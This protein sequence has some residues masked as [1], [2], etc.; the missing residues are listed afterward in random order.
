MAVAVLLTS[1]DSASADGSQTGLLMG[2]VVDGAGLPLPQVE[3][4]VDG[5]Q[6]DRSAITDIEGYFRFPSLEIGNYEVEAELLGLRTTNPVRVYLDTTTTIQVTLS[7]EESAEMAAPAASELI[8]VE[9]IAPLVDRF[10]TQV[11]ATVNRKFLDELPVTRFYQSVALLLPGVVG[12][13][14]GNPNVSGSLREGNLYLIDGVDTTDPTTGLFGL[15]LNYEAIEEVAVTTASPT[16]LYGRF[17]GALINVV[18]Q[19]GTDDFRGTARWISTSSDW[20][21]EYEPEYP[22]ISDEISAANTSAGDLNSTW[23]AT[24]AGPIVPGKAW[25]F[26]AFEAGST[27]DRFRPS[28]DGEEWNSNSDLEGSLFK[29]TYRPSES[30]TITLQR[31]ADS[32]SFAE[33]SPFDRSA[34]ENQTDEKGISEFTIFDRV[35]GDLFALEGRSQKGDFTTAQWIGAPRQ[36]LA[37]SASIAMQNRRLERGLRN[38]RGLTGGA[39]HDTFEPTLFEDGIG[40]F[41]SG[42]YNGISD[43]GLEERERIQADVTGSWFF[44][45][46]FADHDLKVGIDYQRTD[47]SRLFNFSGSAGIDKGTGRSVSGQFRWNVSSKETAGLR[48]TR[49]P[50]SFCPSHSSTSGRETPPKRR[51][52]P[53]QFSSKTRSS[54]AAGY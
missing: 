46:G 20:N 49:P 3:V 47:S 7:E 5:P 16:S 54:R 17:S 36:N 45:S 43:V 39:L 35:P 53:S 26:G 14:D 23:A 38:Q 48:S 44:R 29:L 37:V 22:S 13:E 6:T 24:L 21:A 50:V 32:A 10:R 51:W 34:S 33:F 11:G 52:R 15:N 12:G 8:E 1:P 2:Q 25:F 18:T 19:A 41:A 28:L 9:A 42:V 30:H 31:T 40:F 4:R 27:T